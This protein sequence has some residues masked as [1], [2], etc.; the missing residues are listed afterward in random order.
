MNN[1]RDWVRYN[2]VAAF[3][4]VTFLIT[5]GLGFSF[6]L[7]M[8]QGVELL[9][10]IISVALCGPGLAGII[11]SRICSDEPKSGSLK[12]IWIAFLIALVISA[13]AFLANNSIINHAPIS[14]VM[15]VFVLVM[16]IPVAFIISQ[17]FSRVPSVRHFL[18]S[19]IEMRRVWGWLLLA[20]ATTTCL[21]VLSI[22][23]SNSLGRGSVQISSLS[24]RGF[25]LIK[26]V[27]V[28]FFYQLFFFNLTGEEVGWRG[29]A[30]PRLQGRFNPL[31]ASIIL[32]IIWA[33]WHALFWKAGGDPVFSWEFWGETLFKLFPATVLL[34]WFY[35]RSSGSILV[36][37]VTHAAQN[38]VF[39]Y[40]PNVDWPVHTAIMYAFAVAVILM[41]KMWQK[42]PADHPA[43]V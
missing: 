18:A 35:T 24:F 27:A 4:I 5:F 31:I 3:L 9:A 39:A 12:T 33:L 23:I 6:D 40:M 26:M 42:L 7:V 2:Q 30:L 17:A 14:P 36:A 11:V 20:L 43:A 22:I 15:I 34:N 38:T 29:F 10:P 37:G 21:S 16:A 32:T 8:N 41:D 13:L 19:L 28:T 25:T 1:L